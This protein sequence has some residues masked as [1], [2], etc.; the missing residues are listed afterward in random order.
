MSISINKISSCQRSAVTLFQP[1]APTKEL[2]TSKKKTSL[3]FNQQNFPIY[4][5]GLSGVGKTTLIDLLEKSSS[6]LFYIPKVS[7]TRQ[8]RKDDD[9]RYIEYVSKEDFIQAKDRGDFFTSTS[10]ESLKTDYGYRTSNLVC[11][12]KHPLMAMPPDRIEEINR[13]PGMKIYIEGDFH[14]GL[15]LRCDPK[16]VPI[17]EKA[18]RAAL[19]QLFSQPQFLNKMDIIFN[20]QFGIPEDS[21][22]KLKKIVEDKLLSQPSHPYF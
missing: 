7:I 5:F 8:P 6:D 2:L 4:F 10:L 9:P 3:V 12:N 17:R 18:N 11:T 13:L 21:A 15:T 22:N 19:E 1:K 20:N 16:E 14:K